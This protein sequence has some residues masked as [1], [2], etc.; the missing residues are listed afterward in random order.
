M[1]G[2]GIGEW[3]PSWDWS[4]G[5]PGNKVLLY[6]ALASVPLF[7]SG[8]WQMADTPKQNQVFLNSLLPTNAYCNAYYEI[9]PDET[10]YLVIQN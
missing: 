10:T 5:P 8:T 4:Q 9:K 3:R 6:L 1:K 7:P 2:M